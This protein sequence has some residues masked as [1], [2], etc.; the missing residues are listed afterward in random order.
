MLFAVL[1]AFLL[2]C[3]STVVFAQGVTTSAINGRVVTITSEP[4]PNAN[5]VVIHQPTGT[6]YG[7][8]S[9][10]D[11]RF[12]FP[13]IR[14]GGPYVIR[15]SHVGFQDDV[16]EDVFLALGESRNITS[17]MLEVGVTLEEVVVSGRY[18]AVFNAGRT[19]AS[20]NVSTKQINEMPSIS[21][22]FQDLTKLS[23]QFSGNSYSAAGRNNRFNNLQ[24]DGAQYNDMFGLGSTGL[25]GGQIGLN[26]IALDAIQE[27]QIV[28]AP[29]DVTMGGFTGGG[30]NAITKSGTNTVA[31]SAYFYGRNESLVGDGPN[32]N[33][34]E[35]FVET[36]MGFTVGGPIIQ[37][38]LFFFLS[39]EMARDDRPLTNVSLLEGPA[40]A[41]ATADRFKN[42]MS[43]QYGVDVGGYNT[44][45][46][47]SPNSKLFARIDYNISQ[48]HRL[49]LR[50]NYVDGTSDRLGWRSRTNEL[51][52]DSHLYQFKSKTHST[53]MQLRST[54]S[55]N[56][57]NELIVGYKTITDRRGAEGEP[58]TEL[59][60]FEPGL[61][62][63]AG[64]E[65]FS[66]ANELDQSIFEFTNNINY[67]IG[68]HMITLGTHNEFYSFR[69][70]FIRSYFGFYEFQSLDDLEAG[71]PSFFQRNYSRTNDPLQSAEF[72]SGQLG[73]YLQDKWTV[74][75][76]LRL[77]FGVRLDMPVF[78]DRP[79]Y[80]PQ[81]SQTFPGYRTDDVPEGQILF[82]PRFGFNYDLTGDRSTQIRG[83]A[84]VF[85]GTMPFVWM[86]NN[87]GNT[88]LL[89]AEV[90]GSG[91]DLPVSFDPN[92][93][94]GVGDPGTG[95]PL[96]RSEI[97]L[98]DPEFK[99][100]QV[101][102][103]NVAVDQ[104]LP[105]G[106]T[107]TAEFVY[108][109]A[110]NDLIYEQLNIGPQTSTIPVEGRP[111]FG[112]GPDTAGHFFDV[113]L[114]TNTSEGKSYNV[115]ATL[116]RIV[117]Q[118]LS[119]IGGY[120]YGMAQDQ[121]SV[122]SSQARSQ[123]RYSPVPGDPN[124]PPLTTSQYET[125]HRLFT[126]LTY[127][128]EFFQKA[129]TMISL[130]YNG[131]SGRPFSYIVRGDVNGDGFDYNDLF[132]IPATASD[133]I[134]TTDNWDA[135]NA[136]IEND[137]Y[138]SQNRGEMSVR[139]AAVTPW[140]HLFDL[141]LAQTIPLVSNHKLEFTVDIMN[142][143][144]MLSKDWGNIYFNN[145]RTY[146]LVRLQGFNEEGRPRYSFDGQETP[147]SWDDGRSRYQIMFGLRYSF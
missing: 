130:F 87:F 49:T 82:S 37:D 35:E 92:N 22:S 142:V 2:I 101:F 70:L 1:A 78:F 131:Q 113:L 69:N 64:V 13:T 114:L 138:L 40:G 144:N 68:S 15:V 42:I 122:N 81:L 94:P 104:V 120:T 112:R 16:I 105:Y 72:S 143:A 29:Y 57:F 147:F 27:F 32:N 60:V 136:F 145:I 12:N 125:R 79:G 90:R 18:D 36:Q 54:F 41:Q 33:P 146:E 98:I 21:R 127:S 135:L 19:G 24:V 61:R 7:T 44:F 117:D 115:S 8:I 9:R 23:P 118:G 30:I 28:V 102:R 66:S 48:N 76:Q 106:F 84:G 139:N 116:Q 50:H 77:T 119:F 141:R 63:V 132:F 108:T 128:A 99:F 51:S 93:Q 10:D 43:N 109:S 58:S 31:G 96:L 100:P 17:Y 67:A 107:G 71:N 88:G 56:L 39:G 52:F 86:S 53:V 91:V 3:S 111:R 45:T 124:S 38:K 133:I 59:H 5:V 126:S 20:T 95:A 134:L 137:D 4:L 123:M 97:N 26:P 85:T 80:N 47:K 25:P 110:I 14:T 140:E 65:R 89:Y 34:F 103:T 73:F 46:R 74:N 75:D 62:L 83:G 129:P 121:N 6:R 11:G 55:N